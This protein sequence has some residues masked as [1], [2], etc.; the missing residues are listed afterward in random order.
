MLFGREIELAALADLVREGVPVALVGEAGVGKTAL[1]QEAARSAGR[2]VLAG[3][4]LATLSWQPYLALSRATGRVFAGGDAT[5]VA[6]DVERAVGDDLLVLDDLHWVDG[7]TREVLRRLVGRISVATAVRRGD[8]AAPDAIALSMDAGFELIP[9]E[10]LGDVDATALVRSINP[11]I[12]GRKLQRVLSLAGGNPLLLEEL[13]R[14]EEPTA[15]LRLAIA[16]RLRNLTDTAREV[17]AM[18]GLIGRPVDRT[19]IGEALSE[20]SRAALVT[21]VEGLVETRHALVAET[22]VESLSDDERR[23]LHGRI[24]TFLTEPGE[25]ARHLAAAADHERARAEALRAADAARTPGERAA[26]LALA[27]ACSVGSHSDELRLS[28][29]WALTDANDPTGV[30]ELMSRVDSDNHAMRAQVGLLLWR[31]RQIRGDLEGAR[32]AWRQGMDVAA[33]TDSDIELLLSIEGARLA[34]LVDYDAE[35]ALQKA[36][37][38]VAVANERRIHLAAAHSVRGTARFYSNGHPGWRDDMELALAR[39]RHDCDLDVEHRTANNLVYGLMV[40]GSTSKGIDLALE[41]ISRARASRLRDWELRFR[42]WIVGLRWHAGHPTEAVDEGHK[43][44][45]E[46]GVAID[47][48]LAEFFLCQALIDVGQLEEAGAIARKRVAEVVD[49]SPGS[50]DPEA[51]AEAFWSLAELEFASGRYREAEVAARQVGTRRMPDEIP[52]M[53]SILAAWACHES[54]TEVPP[55]RI[56]ETNPIAGGAA[57]EAAGIELL[58]G[59]RCR[60]AA[61]LFEDAADRWAGRHGRG[62][63]RSRWAHGEALRRGGE[64]AAVPALLA[65]EELAIERGYRTLLAR[66]HRSLRRA[67]VR[68]AAPRVRSAAGLTGRELEV[69]DLVATGLTNAEIGGRLGVNRHTVARLISSASLKLGAKNRAHAAALATR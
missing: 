26:H 65:A 42:A 10:P 41:M 67:G 66:I 11:R 27:A 19:L 13:A 44:I 62:E 59:G 25:I 38:A 45:D 30:E 29:A 53:A 43:L 21:D 15:S 7:A 50:E 2:R 69:L 33:G 56:G 55:I 64:D 6:G 28:A 48:Q 22:I 32:R 47:R 9:V 51:R 61:L 3:G 60:E 63:I 68:R 8:P 14:T 5:A 1:L 35:A 16:A 40:H 4:G 12:T 17:I 36:E 24:A 18:L 54:G 34:L 20:L 31:T 37:T 23:R 57:A 39:S 46:M 58:H 49:G 52:V